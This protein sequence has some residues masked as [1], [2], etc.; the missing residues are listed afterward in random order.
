M[1]T[2][3]E[4]A[5]AAPFDVW[6][7]HRGESAFVTTEQI[8]SAPAPEGLGVA[9]LEKIRMGAIGRN[10][11]VRVPLTR[12]ELQEMA[13]LVVRE[14]YVTDLVPYDAADLYDVEQWADDMF[15][16]VPDGEEAVLSLESNCKER[17]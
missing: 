5:R 10:G 7:E 14:S 1:W 6:G 11:H 17:V 4:V 15:T 16:S 9:L 3:W 8:V 2:T 13:L 12:G